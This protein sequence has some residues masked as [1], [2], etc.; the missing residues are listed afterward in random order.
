MTLEHVERAHADAARGAQHR[1][2]HGFSSHQAQAFEQP[3]RNT[4]AAAVTLSI[5]IEQAAVARQQRAA[6][7]QAG[8]TLEQL[9]VRS[10]IIDATTTTMHRRR[11]H[12]AIDT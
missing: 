3:N 9:S 11:S 5:A 8:V 7:L 4:G 6:V 2:S 10:P 1:D 12:G